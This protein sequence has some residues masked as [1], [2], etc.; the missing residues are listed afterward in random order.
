VGCEGKPTTHLHLV[1]RLRMHGAMPPYPLR[2]R[3]GRLNKAQGNFTFRFSRDL[4]LN[5]SGNAQFFVCNSRSY[6]N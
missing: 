1:L 4:G 5:V 6:H 2:L 3:G